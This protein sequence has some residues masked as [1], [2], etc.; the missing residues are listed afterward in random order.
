MN[1]TLPLEARIWTA[2]ECGSYLGVT[3]EHFLLR[4]RWEDGFPRSLKM[5]NSKRP[6]W[7]AKAVVDWA[8]APNA[9]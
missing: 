4:G 1:D 8:L 5:S 6:R 3:R 7:S 2:A 9:G